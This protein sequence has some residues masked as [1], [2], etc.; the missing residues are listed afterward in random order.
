MTVPRVSCFREA[1]LDF[2]QAELGEDGDSMVMCDLSKHRRMLIHSI[3]G[4]GPGRFYQL[5]SAHEAIGVTMKSYSFPCSQTRWHLQ[6]RKDVGSYHRFVPFG[7]SGC[8]PTSMPG[9]RL[10]TAAFDG[11][12][13]MFNYTGGGLIYVRAPWLQGG[14][15]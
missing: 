2:F 12:R 7:G 5:A 3:V 13:R 4:V 10:T 6:L 15:C 9:D 11:L 1:V 8:F 14:F